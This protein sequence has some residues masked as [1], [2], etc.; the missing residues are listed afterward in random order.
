[1]TSGHE[2]LAWV[3]KR[4]LPGLYQDRAI[5]RLRERE[6]GGKRLTG[7]V[8]LHGVGRQSGT[9]GQ[10]HSRV[11]STSLRT[12]CALHSQSGRQTASS[13]SGHLASVHGSFVT[14]GL[15]GTASTDRE[16]SAV[17]VAVPRIGEAGPM[18][19][20]LTQPLQAPHFFLI[21]ERK[22]LLS[23]YCRQKMQPAF[24]FFFFSPHTHPDRER[25]RERGATYFGT[26]KVDGE[27]LS[28]CGVDKEDECLPGWQS[29]AACCARSR[30]DEC[31]LVAHVWKNVIDVL[32]AVHHL[33][34]S[35]T[36]THTYTLDS[37]SLFPRPWK[38]HERALPTHHQTS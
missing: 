33:D 21:M 16:R 25:E 15:I 17:A 19:G 30:G 5:Q 18:T 27:W 1:M 32:D 4:N 14:E 3:G 31:C 20:G 9:S 24:F 34:C 7:F 29:N 11:T 37:L 6:K 10:S 36:H 26:A 38:H 28:R 12:N 2:P 22:P 35:H 8:A 23:R 13:T